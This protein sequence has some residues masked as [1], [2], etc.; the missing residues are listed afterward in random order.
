MEYGPLIERA[1]RLTWQNRF[2]WVLGLFATSTVGSCSPA[3]GSNSGWQVDR[4]EVE[5]FYSPDLFRPF[6]EPNPWLSQNIGWILLTFIAVALLVGIA[7][8][9]VSVAAQG[10][11]ASATGELGIGRRTSGGAAW[12]TGFRLFWRYLL[13]WLIIVGLTVAVLLAIAL[14]VGVAVAIG[15]G[16]DGGRNVLLVIA[17]VL[18]G[19]PAVLLAIL[20]FTVGSVVVAFA[21][22]AIAL[23]DLPSTAG[24]GAGYR[25]VRQNLGTSALAWLVSLAL[26]IVSGIAIALAAVA[27]LLPLGGLGFVLYFVSGVSTALILYGIVAVLV[28]IAGLW[29]LG[30]IVN[31]FFWN[32][33]TLVYLRLTGRLTARLE[34]QAEG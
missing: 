15:A 26:S 9:I 10:G 11:M 7:F 32:Y 30:G 29:L 23:E 13:M 34:P 25:L 4:S 5:R 1:W 8:T 31:T 19:I 3:G 22:R 18:V 24:L 6:Q 16:L 17:A 27:L 21:Q 33:W 14:I 12:R 2:L 28:L 20:A